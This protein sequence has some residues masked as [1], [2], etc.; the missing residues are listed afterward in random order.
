MPILII[1]LFVLMTV[2]SIM[3]VVQSCSQTFKISY[4]ETLLERY[5]AE[6]DIKLPKNYRR[7]KVAFGH[8]IRNS[9]RR[10]YECK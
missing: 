5:E 4:Y 1:I 10:K 2:L 7:I 8:L 3:G 9:N 6:I